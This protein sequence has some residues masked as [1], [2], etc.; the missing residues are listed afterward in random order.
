MHNDQHKFNYLEL[1]DNEDDDTLNP[2]VILNVVDDEIIP[3]IPE[4]EDVFSSSFVMSHN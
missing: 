1:N 3:S 4:F 2:I